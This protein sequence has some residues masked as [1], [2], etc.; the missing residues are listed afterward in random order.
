MPVAMAF[1]GYLIGYSSTASQV[2]RNCTRVLPESLHIRAVD[3][4]N[5]KSANGFNGIPKPVDLRL[6]NPAARI[7]LG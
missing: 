7:F 6:G 5:R 2:A 3:C 4:R 1:F